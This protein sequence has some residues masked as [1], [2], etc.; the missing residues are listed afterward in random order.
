MRLSCKKRRRGC[1]PGPLPPSLLAQKAGRRHIVPLTKYG[2]PHSKS[3][4]YFHGPQTSCKAM[5]RG[6]LF[7]VR[8]SPP[9]GVVGLPTVRTYYL[10]ALTVRAPKFSNALRRQGY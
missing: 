2:W 8:P 3:V 7:F 9:Q 1:T 5:E 10:Q 6:T 4:F